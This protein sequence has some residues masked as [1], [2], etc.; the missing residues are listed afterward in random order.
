MSGHSSRMPCSEIGRWS[1]EDSCCC[2]RWTLRHG[3]VWY[4]TVR[5]GTLAA[6]N[7][8]IAP[9]KLLSGPKS[10]NHVILHSACFS[11]VHYRKFAIL[12]H[13]NPKSHFME[14]AC[15]ALMLYLRATAIRVTQIPQL[16]SGCPLIR[17]VW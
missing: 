12:R 2:H 9:R 11:R 8:L 10:L 6:T 3:T 5:Y 4:R 16:M 7:L 17:A 1:Q 13:Y 15:R 14:E